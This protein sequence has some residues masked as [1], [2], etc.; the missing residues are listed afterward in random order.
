M[1]EQA[2]VIIHDI[3]SHFRH[4]T[5]EKFFPSCISLFANLFGDKIILSSSNG[6]FDNIGAVFLYPNQEKFYLNYFLLLLNFW[7]Y[8]PTENQI[9]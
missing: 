8:I 1:S 4:K 2:I 5:K 7:E 6:S 9:P 3:L